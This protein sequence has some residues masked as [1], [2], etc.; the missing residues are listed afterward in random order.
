MK[1]RWSRLVILFLSVYLWLPACPA[2]AAAG[3]LAALMPDLTGWKQ[4]R[5]V[6]FYTPQDLYKYIDGAAELYL[7]YRFQQLAAANYQNNRNDSVDVEV[8]RHESPVHSFGIYS[9]E[10]PSKGQFIAVGAQGYLGGGTL[11]FFSGDYYVKLY[12]Y[13]A[14][15]DGDRTLTLFADQIAGKLGTG[16]RLPDILD[17]FPRPGKVPNS[18]RFTAVNFLGHDFLH[19]G[20]TADY[21][22]GGK[23]FQ[24]VIIEAKEAA[25]A[26]NML[27]RYLAL[28]RQK[29]ADP[30]R[31]GNFTV[32][33]PY[34]GMIQLTFR[35]KYL[36]G[37][38]GTDAA[39]ARPLLDDMGKRLRARP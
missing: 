10:R 28:S 25:D 12:Y 32:S 34:N 13:G 1:H 20:F 30:L 31:E 9:Q 4:T 14:A 36:W 24:L 17:C 37:A 19:S 6:D 21:E 15:K 38:M 18:E 29:S 11:N 27:Q 3:D 23:R 16:A 35:G 5:A 2:L 39:T 22:T 8:Y 7:S 26:R 33:D